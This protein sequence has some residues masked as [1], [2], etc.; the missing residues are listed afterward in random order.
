MQ[1]LAALKKKILINWI[2]LFSGSTAGAAL[3]LAATIVMT[4]AIGVTDVGLVT[5]VQT[6]WRTLEGFLSFQSYQI[7]IKNG[8]DILHGSSA[9]SF[10]AL[11]KLCLLADACMAVFGAVIGLVGFSTFHDQ[12]HIPGTVTGMGLLGV[13]TMVTMITGAPMGIL[14]LYDKLNIV[15][16]RDVIVNA[17]R[18]A[19][20]GIAL[21]FHPNANVFIAIWIV[22]EALGNVVIFICGMRELHRQGHTHII[23]ASLSDGDA[24]LDIRRIITALFTLNFG[25]MIRILSE[26]GD[27]LLVNAYTGAAA[28]GIYKIAKNF[29]GIVYKFTGPLAQSIYPEMAKAVSAKN[30]A[31]FRHIM[32]HTC[33]QGGALGIATF[34]AWALIGPFIIHMTVGDTY[35]NALPVI[36]IFTGG[37]AVAFFGIGFNPALYAFHRLNHYVLATVLCTLAYFIVALPL[38]PV[39]GINGSAY[40][41]MACYLS[42]FIISAWLVIKA[43]RDTQWS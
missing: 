14:R 9:G 7:L 12:M 16:L 37:Y 38:V 30:C 2:K 39:I 18:L 23:A 20:N 11:V 36:L 35:Q 19:S 15:A 22:T 40:G 42:G 34:A 27:T 32:L 31:A 29:A 25:T 43:Y 26:E 10:R 28:A 17:T 13:F 6:F 5:V 4:R 24:Q 8:A 33:L 21:F 3:G 1:N 41:Q